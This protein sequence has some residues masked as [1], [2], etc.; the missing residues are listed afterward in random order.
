MN[1]IWT[2]KTVHEYVFPAAFKRSGLVFSNVDE[3]QG[4]KI[5]YFCEVFK[6]FLET[7]GVLI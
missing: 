7:E 1:V 3:I 4:M 5:K 2:F 6:D